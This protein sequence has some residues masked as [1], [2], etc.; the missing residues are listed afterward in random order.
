MRP[1]HNRR[2]L[3]DIR[4]L[5]QRET[6]VG[7]EKQEE[8]YQ[9]NFTLGE[10]QRI[11]IFNIFGI[12]GVGKSSLL[13]RFQQTAKSNG[14]ITAWND[15]TQKDILSVMENIAKQFEKQEHE[16][17]KFSKSYQAYLQ[18][19]HELVTDPNA[20]SGLAD[21]IGGLTKAGI[22]FGQSTPANLLLGFVDA[23]TLSKEAGSL[24]GTLV[25]HLKRKLSEEDA[26]LVQN[27]I[28]ELTP[29]FIEDLWDVSQE[30]FIALFFDTF[31]YTGDYLEDWLIEWL[32]GHYGDLPP[33]IVLAIAGQGE[34][35]KNKWKD[36]EGMLCRFSLNPFTE[37]EALKYLLLRGIVS[38]DVIQ[39]ILNLSK[40]LPLLVAT[41]AAEHPNDLSQIGDINSTAIDC[42]LKWVKDPNRR[43]ILLDAALA[44]VV[45]RDI[46]AV[47]IGKG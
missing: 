34:L 21:F 47:L 39:V 12:G 2:S 3:Q 17:K 18:R 43:R 37:E 32:N 13:T 20:P 38:E 6:F 22:R 23:D 19:C 27:P 7:R 46:L 5:R 8:S 1:K 40:R 10:E 11:Y 29:L 25:A 26:R 44:R 36:Y 16:F 4:K 14:A 24:A 42:F 41:L 45:N 15:E 28:D 35:D 9:R 33:N 30:Q 31:E